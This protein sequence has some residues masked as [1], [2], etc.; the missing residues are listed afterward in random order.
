MLSQIF[1]TAGVGRTLVN[2]LSNLS[3]NTCA[4][5]QRIPLNTLQKQLGP[6]TG[7]S[8]HRFAFGKDDRQLNVSYQRKSVSA[9][10]NY[11]IRLTTVSYLMYTFSNM[12]NTII[13]N[14]I[15]LSD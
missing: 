9:E 14:N 7:Q 10:M 4:D 1:H 2:K 12:N 6:K 13:M 5:L 8:L 15:F 3:V 11:A